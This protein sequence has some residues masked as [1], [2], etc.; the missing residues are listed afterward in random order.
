MLYLNGFESWR[1]FNWDTVYSVSKKNNPRRK[2]RSN[3]W[4][5]QIDFL[6]YCSS[7]MQ[8]RWANQ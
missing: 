5:L 1:H 3:R 4:K 6:R 8:V 2:Q 7:I